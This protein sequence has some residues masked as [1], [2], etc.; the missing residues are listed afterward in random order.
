[1]EIMY[2]VDGGWLVHTNRRQQDARALVDPPLHYLHIILPVP[3]VDH[4]KCLPKLQA[5]SLQA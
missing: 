3:Y 2:E 4:W 5:A 1:M